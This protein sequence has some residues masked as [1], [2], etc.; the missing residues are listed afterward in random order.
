MVKKILL[1]LVALIAVA[2]AVVM[3]LAMKQP[4][5]MKIERTGTTSAS[6]ATVYAIVTDFHRFHEWSPWQKLDPN[7]KSDISG[8]APGVGSSY[9]WAG[10]DK[11]GEGRMTIVDAMPDSRVDMRLEF[12]KPF[13]D[14]CTTVFALAPTGGG[15]Q[16]TWTML[17]HYNMVSKVMC[18]FMD[19]DKMVGSQFEEGLANLARVAEATQPVAPADST[20]VPTPPM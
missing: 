8:S 12:V 10:N 15:T 14:T 9:H 4:D 1:T 20:T 16:V 6:P 18:V 11:A 2:V 5:E 7:M 3:G 17:G 19:M 13:A